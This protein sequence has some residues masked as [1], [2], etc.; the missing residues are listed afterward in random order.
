M[1]SAQRKP[2]VT[3]YP[4]GHCI[5]CSSCSK[6]TKKCPKCRSVIISRDFGEKSNNKRN[7][8]TEKAPTKKIESKSIAKNITYCGSKNQDTAIKTLQENSYNL[9]AIVQICLLYRQY[10]ILEEQLSSSILDKILSKI[11]TGLTVLVSQRL[12]AFSSIF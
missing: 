2:T 1:L 8:S 9:C 4:C 3:Y 5:C 11:F 10:N 12:C 6:L 7:N